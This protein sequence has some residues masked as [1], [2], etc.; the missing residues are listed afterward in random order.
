MGEPVSDDAQ[1]ASK[2]PALKT[3]E[4]RG[5]G[6]TCAGGST[7]NPPSSVS[8]D[9]S[10]TKSPPQAASLP[11]TQ[12]RTVPVTMPSMPGA[13]DTTLAASNAPPGTGLFGSSLFG[14]SFSKA[15][16]ES[17]NPF[18]K[19]TSNTS[20]T[21]TGAGKTAS[22]ATSTG[23]P[24]AVFATST[25]SGGII[26]GN[27]A[28]PPAFASTETVPKG[29][30]GGSEAIPPPNNATKSLFGQT[31]GGHTKSLPSANAPPG[32]LFALPVP[33]SSST[34]DFSTRGGFSGVPSKPPS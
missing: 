19:W 2:A 23:S 15:A 25:K 5:G 8:Q 34:S 32:G 28:T 10:S 4:H 18:A 13:Q 27:P 33:T 21:S 12:S 9:P 6:N 14:H 11:P 1:A 26:G 16:A 17:P 24:S 29:G 7:R 20:T 3:A 22:P 31:F 30:F